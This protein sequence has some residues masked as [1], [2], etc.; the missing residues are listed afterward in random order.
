MTCDTCQV[1][2]GDFANSLL[3]TCFCSLSALFKFVHAKKQCFYSVVICPIIPLLSCNDQCLCGVGGSQH[4][5]IKQVKS[6]ST[7]CYRYLL[8]F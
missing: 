1:C 6:F 2:R 8:S 7:R 4:L 5:T 3:G